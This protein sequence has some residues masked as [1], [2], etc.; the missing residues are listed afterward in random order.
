MRRAW[1]ICLAIAAWLGATAAAAAQDDIV[2]EL[3]RKARA[4][5]MDDGFCERA[6]ERLERLGQPHV[7]ERLNETLSRADGETVTMLFVSEEEMPARTC[8]YLVFQPAAMKGGRK[9]R[10]S[11]IFGCMIG[12]DCRVSANQPI[13]ERSPGMWD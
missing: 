12:R 7:R 13:C 9:C 8:L 1:I 11:T 10:A 5:D 2:R 3:Q 4:K 6:S